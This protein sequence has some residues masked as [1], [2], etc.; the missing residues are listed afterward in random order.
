MNKATLPLRLLPHVKAE[1]HRVV[2]HDELKTQS[3]R[4]CA[5]TNIA[6]LIN[7]LD[8]EGAIKMIE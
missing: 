2:Q 3:D 5:P 8:M 4:T 1:R 6:S 7:L